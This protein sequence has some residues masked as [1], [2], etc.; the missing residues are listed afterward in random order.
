MF[1]AQTISSPQTKR[2]SLDLE[3]ARA[4]RRVQLVP[5]TAIVRVG[6]EDKPAHPVEPTFA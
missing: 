3:L 4:E 5:V 1:G 6:E 2:R